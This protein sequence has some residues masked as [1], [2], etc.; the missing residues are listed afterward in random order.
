VLFGTELP[1]HQDGF[2][3]AATS[4]IS[5]S[6]RPAV[7]LIFKENALRVLGVTK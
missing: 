3:G 1:V 4:R 2:A 6:T 5:T 7:P